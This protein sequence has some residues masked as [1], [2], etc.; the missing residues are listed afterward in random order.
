VS[1]I[2][3][4][5]ISIYDFEVELKFNRDIDLNKIEVQKDIKIEVYD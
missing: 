3:D 5:S 4:N 2:R 1:I